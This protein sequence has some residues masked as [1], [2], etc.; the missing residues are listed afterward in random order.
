MSL[1][2]DPMAKGTSRRLRLNPVFLETVSVTG[3]KMATDAVEF[4]NAPDLVPTS[5]A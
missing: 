5:M 4:M 3:K 2:N 1:T